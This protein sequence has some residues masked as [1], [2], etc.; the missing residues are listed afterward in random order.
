MIIVIKISTNFGERF[1]CC[2][3]FGGTYFSFQYSAFVSGFCCCFFNRISFFI[4]FCLAN[5]GQPLGGYTVSPIHPYYFGECYY[6]HNI[7][8]LFR[9][10]NSTKGM[11]VLRKFYSSSFFQSK[12]K[13]KL[14]IMKL[15]IIKLGLS[16]VL[17]WDMTLFFI[18]FTGSLNLEFSLTGILAS[19]KRIRREEYSLSFSRG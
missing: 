4:D 12:W 19:P 15:E 3:S 14:F 7:F 9:Q 5:N 18:L 11:Q 16:T 13:Y 8:G 17:S 10:D 1:P 6:F 2:R